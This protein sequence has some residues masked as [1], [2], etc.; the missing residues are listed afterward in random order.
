MSDALSEDS[1][2]MAKLRALG[3]AKAAEGKIVIKTLLH[4]WEI[5]GREHCRFGN[6]PP[7]LQEEAY[8]WMG[9]AP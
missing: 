2:F 5:N 6:W 3:E 9:E 8:R 1:Q 7:H 4:E